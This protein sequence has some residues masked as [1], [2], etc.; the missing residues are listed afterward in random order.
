MGTATKILDEPKVLGISRGN[1][2]S[3]DL[4]RRGANP[5]ARRRLG[6]SHHRSRPGKVD[7]G[8]GAHDAENTESRG[9]Q[10]RG[11]GRCVSR[12]ACRREA[13]R[14]SSARI[15]YNPLGAGS[16]STLE[17][18]E[19][20]NFGPTEVDLSG[21]F[22]SEG[23][24]FVVPEGVTLSG[25]GYLVFSPEP[26]RA[27]P[28]YGLPVALV[29]GPYQGRL[30]NG[31]EVVSISNRHGEVVNRTHFDDDGPWPTLADGLGPSLEF[32]GGNT[33]NDLYFHWAAS[34]SLG[35]HTGRAPRFPNRA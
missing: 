15:H 18:V 25:K 22:F 17:F 10:S 33:K 16:T 12:P 5:D 8:K 30:D 11:A 1:P 23:V 19:V 31:G 20:H 21:W 4:M 35:G 7:A 29:L 9:R 6:H 28:H 13:T 3:S 34:R 24:D 2:R 27:A 32:V 14:S 26:D